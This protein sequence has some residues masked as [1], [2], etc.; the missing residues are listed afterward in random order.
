MIRHEL[1]VVIVVAAAENGVIGRDN[2]LIWRLKTDLQPLPPLTLGRPLIMGRKTFESIGKPLPGRE[3]IVLTRDPALPAE[4]VPSRTTLDA[5]LAMGQ[6]IGPRWGADSVVVGG[7][8]QVYRA[9]ACRSPTGIHLT[10]VHATPRAM[11]CFLP[12]ST[13]QFRQR[14]RRSIR[15][16]PDDEH[17]VRVIDYVGVVRI[18][19]DVWSTPLNRR[20]SANTRNRNQFGRASVDE[21][22]TTPHFRGISKIAPRA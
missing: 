22:A 11:R 3:T 15:A 6:E 14:V 17:A 21:W 9:G 20:A 7:G 5:A 18:P 10:R 19:P 16:G 8:A 2:G 13:A 1:P 4:G 12:S